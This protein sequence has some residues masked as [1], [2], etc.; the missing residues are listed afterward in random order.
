M[1]A[2]IERIRLVLQH[3]TIIYFTLPENLVIGVD[4]RLF[5]LEHLWESCDMRAQRVFTS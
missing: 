2:D 3:K 4:S 1:I 5:V